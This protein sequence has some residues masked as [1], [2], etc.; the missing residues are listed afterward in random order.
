MDD[1]SD[2]RPVRK[3]TWILGKPIL[4]VEVPK[5]EETYG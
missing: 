3:I 5:G 2:A 1:T 4:W